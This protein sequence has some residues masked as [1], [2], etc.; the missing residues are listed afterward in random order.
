MTC[1][2]LCIILIKMTTLGLKV[3]LVFKRLMR[4]QSKHSLNI[5]KV[6]DLEQSEL[7]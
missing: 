7:C 2:M 4:R 1:N 3:Q 5:D 6:I